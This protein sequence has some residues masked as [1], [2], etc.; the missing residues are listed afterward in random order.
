[1]VTML[2]RKPTEQEE[3]T[4]FNRPDVQ[5]VDKAKYKAVFKI[6][7]VWGGE[8]EEE[9]EQMML[10]VN[11]FSHKYLTQI[12]IDALDSHNSSSRYFQLLDDDSKVMAIGRILTEIDAI[13]S[14]KD[15]MPLDWY[16]EDEFG[17]TTIQYYNK[18]GQL[19][20]L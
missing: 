17:C 7:A 12:Q 6:D 9:E 8:T 13:G 2:K 4:M 1:M 15:F 18:D 5:I 19:E 14:E 20:D 11:L 3:V 10:S 16:G